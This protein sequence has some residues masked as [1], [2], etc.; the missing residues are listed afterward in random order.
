MLIK[1]MYNLFLEY[2]LS[3]KST[4]LTE[5]HQLH[6]DLPQLLLVLLDHGL[7]IRR[8]LLAVVEVAPTLVLS[9]VKRQ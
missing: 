6:A 9:R 4:A 5:A 7:A 3:Y 2:S 1:F 8:F